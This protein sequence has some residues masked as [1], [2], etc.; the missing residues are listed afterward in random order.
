MLSRLAGCGG[1]E[2]AFGV[3]GDAI[4]APDLRV[5]LLAAPARTAS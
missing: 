3:C 2:A 1:W 4:A 5:K